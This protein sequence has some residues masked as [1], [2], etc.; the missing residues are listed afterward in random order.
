[1]RFLVPVI[2]WD[3]MGCSLLS[4]CKSLH[5]RGVYGDEISPGDL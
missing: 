4:W 3:F 2:Q 1:M 5:E